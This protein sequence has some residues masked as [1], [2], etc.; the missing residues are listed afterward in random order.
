H[1]GRAAG[2]AADPQPRRRLDEW[3]AAPVDEVVLEPDADAL[4][5]PPPDAVFVM[6]FLLEPASEVGDVEA[7]LEGGPVDGAETRVGHPVRTKETTSPQLVDSIVH[8][9]KAA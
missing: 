2:D 8:P 9:E 1:A 4:L 5:A 7:E 3:A 6:T